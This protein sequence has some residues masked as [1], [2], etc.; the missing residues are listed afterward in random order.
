[1]RES[2]GGEERSVSTLGKGTHQKKGAKG[3][4]LDGVMSW[5]AGG[6]GGGGVAAGGRSGGRSETVA[7]GSR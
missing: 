1:M 5:A 4:L 6:A 3:E 2:R 7:Q